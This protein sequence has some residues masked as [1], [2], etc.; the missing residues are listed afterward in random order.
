MSIDLK[1]FRVTLNSLPKEGIVC[2]LQTRC[3]ILIGAA[4]VIFSVSVSGQTSTSTESDARTAW[5][6]PNLQ[7]VWS[8]A[9]VT[10]LQRPEGAAEFLT[11]EEVAEIER[12]AVVEA[13]DEARGQTQQADVRGAYNDF[14]WDRGTQVA[15]SQRTSLIFDPQDGRLPALTSSAKAYADSDEALIARE[16]RR[17]M[18]PAASY[19]DT[20]LWDRCLTRG[21]PLRPGPYNN[22]FQIFQTENHLVVLHEMIHDARIIP[23]ENRAG[24]VSPAIPQWFGT[25]SAHWEGDTLIVVTKNFAKKQE[26]PFEPQMTSAGM[27]LTERFSPRGDGLLNYEYTVDHPTIYSEPWSAQLPLRRLEGNTY[28]YACHEGNYGLTGILQGSRNIEN[29]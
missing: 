16:T 3:A 1:K 17:G 14:W 8:T 2:Y 9:T 12:Q 29:R 28:E 10:P 21:L 26:L 27:T 22:N 24:I 13:N 18:H 15:G 4:G 25:S 11:D 6:T 7:G 19:T 23:I 5:G 20:D